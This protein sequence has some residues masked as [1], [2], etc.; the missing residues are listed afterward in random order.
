MQE[1]TVIDRSK[2]LFDNGYGCA[3]AVLMAFAEFKGI[4]SPLIPRI[5]T[6]FCGGVGRT[7]GTCGAVSGG[8][9]ALSLVYGRDDLQTSKDPLNGRIQTFV[10]DFENRF[11]SINCTALTGCDLSAPGGPEKFGQMK[12][13]PTCQ[14][15]VGEAARLLIPLMKDPHDDL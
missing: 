3:E 7:S 4:K 9:L 11:G 13:H 12:L 5:A 1:E 15:F 8:V 10:R 14:G 2:Q 6:G